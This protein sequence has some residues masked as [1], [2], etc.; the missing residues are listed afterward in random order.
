MAITNNDLN[1]ISA[2]D[3][4]KE[5]AK[6]KEFRG[7]GSYDISSF[8]GEVELIL[9]LFDENQAVKNY[10]WERHIKTKIQGEALQII[11]TLNRDS[12]WDEVKTELIRNFGIRESYHQLFHQA[13][14]T[15]QYNG[16]WILKLLILTAIWTL[17]LGQ[18][19][20]DKIESNK[21]YIEIQTGD[22]D[23][24]KSYVTILHVINP[25]EI[26]NLLN[27]I[28]SNIKSANLQV[29]QAILN[30]QIKF[31]RSKINTITPHRQKRGL[32]NAVGTVQKWLYGT[33][34]DND[35]QDLE[36]HLNIIDTNNHKAIETINK[37]IDINTNF[38]KTFLELKR[39]MHNDRDMISAKLNSIGSISDI[40]LSREKRKLY[41]IGKGQLTTLGCFDAEIEIN[42]VVL[43]I[44]FHV[45]R[46]RDIPY[47]A[48][49]GSDVLKD[50]ELVFR[51]G[52]VTF[53]KTSTGVVPGSDG[54]GGKVS[55]AESE[56]QGGSSEEVETEMR[57]SHRKSVELTGL[58]QGEV[59][60]EGVSVEWGNGFL[61]EFEA[62][63]LAENE[64]PEEKSKGIDVSHLDGSIAKEVERLV[65][66]YMPGKP[67]SAPV[68]MKLILSDDRPV[69]QRPRR[70]SVED[71]RYIDEQ[72]QAMLEEGIIQYSTSEYAS[73]VVL[74]K[75][76]DGTKRF[77]CD[78]R[79][80]NERIVRDN[81]PMALV[82]EVLDKLQGAKVFTT[83]D[84]KNGFYHVPVE[85][86][87]RKYTSFVTH[88]GQF[89]FCFVPF[90]ITN[91]P[92]VFCRFIR[93]VF[94]NM[95]KDD[96]I[97]IYM[98]DIVI[99]AKDENESLE[100][101]RRVL[102]QASEHGL[103]IKWEKCQ[104]IK[105]QINFLGYILENGQILPSVE[106]TRA[107]RNFP[108]PTSKKEI[109]RF[110]GLT[111]FFRRFIRDYSII[112]KPLSDLLRMDEAFK[113]GVDQLLA[114]EE[115]K[116]ALI[117]APALKLFDP[118]AETEVHADA[119]KQ[120]FGAVLLQR[121]S[122]DRLFHPVE[123]MSRKTTWAEE[124]YSAFEL[125]VL[126]VVKALQK[127]NLY[128]KDRKFK[129]VSDCNAFAMTVKK[130]DVPDRVMRWAMYLQ[131]YDYRVEH[132]SGSRMR[133]VDALSRVYCLLAEDSLTVRL[134]EAQEQ[135]TWIRAV[136]KI[137][138]TGSYENFFLKNGIVYCDTIKELLV[139]PSSMET[140]IIKLA[141][142]QNHFARKKTQ[143]LVEK[144]YY[145]PDLTE[146]VA[147]V[148]KRDAWNA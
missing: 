121:D 55:K 132:R 141:H 105:K 107:V 124:K 75:K 139:V 92:A 26:S 116:K 78:F 99:P 63:C 4:L 2:S 86:D 104:F 38:N 61:R 112:A 118:S 46:E 83:L 60:R 8:I 5:A 57:V 59:S 95:L 35:R 91:S 129:I 43:E 146:K 138:E 47:A 71:Q 41:G 54:T 15:R 10:V 22:A 128:L 48:I 53:K 25:L 123:Y 49:I 72:V 58:V 36:Q 45:V 111:S 93:A 84:L 133:H 108:I 88:S 103:Q 125:E 113:M 51:Q 16:Q 135:D 6:I 31:I 117:N 96:T 69:W 44:T 24:V 67:S 19:T 37:Q 27:E 98:D 42:E 65:N 18:V 94:Q 131:E 28:E 115:L 100:K 62:L 89:E 122:E 136:K 140:E 39:L 30:M 77:C 3:L 52:T 142:D 64:G 110:L 81:F 109:Q 90:G 66:T 23:I 144:N 76:K 13:I 137:L 79:K 34:D 80:I 82:D 130:R 14:T 102:R 32:L 147:K 33:M 148:I 101:L 20:I 12:S 68:Q 74:T 143:E 97:I 114:V 119:S 40:E 134:R 127:W 50:V 17:G 29:G 145:I 73:P 70:T 120:G 1:R 11:R 7:D 85:P 126:A 56:C 9:P 106:K 21:G 87:S